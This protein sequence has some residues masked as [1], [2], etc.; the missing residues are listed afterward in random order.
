MNKCNTI[1]RVTSAD[2]DSAATWAPPKTRPFEVTGMLGMLVVAVAA[3][4]AVGV[5]SLL[6]TMPGGTYAIALQNSGVTGVSTI[7]ALT[8]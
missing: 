3:A 4:L 1:S 2:F 7:A 5:L 8:T 6:I